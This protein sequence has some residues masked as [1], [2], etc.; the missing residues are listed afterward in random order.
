[1]DD[2]TMTAVRAGLVL[3][4]ALVLQAAFVSEAEL[5]GAHGEILLLV[6]VVAALT[7]GPERGGAAGFVAGLAVDLLVRT[8]F[9]LTAL[10]Y[11]LVGHGLGWLRW[12]FLRSSPWLPFI[13][14]VVGSVTG[15]GL[16]AVGVSLVGEVNVLDGGLVAV[17]LAVSLWNTL[18]V[19]PALR[20]ADWVGSP[21]SR[22]AAGAR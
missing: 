11:G 7:G 18:L 2:R 6:P 1:M 15:V 20:I 12:G 19:V 16:F 13:A 9:G 21:R 17:A 5:F 14:S 8:P 4:V 22:R 3:L 10:T